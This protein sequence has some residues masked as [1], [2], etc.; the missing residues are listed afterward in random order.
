MIQNILD[1]EFASRRASYLYSRPSMILF[2][3]KAAFPS[4]SH[5]YMWDM[6]KL[7]GVHVYLIH[8]FQQF[9]RG[10]LQRIKVRKCLSKGFLAECGVRQGCPLSPLLF[11]AVVDVLLRRLVRRYEG[12][13]LRAFADDIG[14]VSLYLS[15]WHGILGDFV[16]FGNISGLHLNMPKCVLVPLWR[17]HISQLF[18]SL[19]DDFPALSRMQIAYAAKY[20]GVWLG[21]ESRGM[22]WDGAMRKFVDCARRWSVGAWGLHFMAR[23]YNIYVVS[24]LSYIAQFYP[25]SAAVLAAERKAVARCLP[26]PAN[27][28]R[29]EEA[30]RL[31]DWFSLGVQFTS[32]EHLSLASRLRVVHHEQVELDNILASLSE[33][34]ATGGHRYPEWSE[35]YHDHVF[36]ALFEA[37]DW[38]QARGSGIPDISRLA[39]EAAPASRRGDAGDVSRRLFQRTAYSLAISKHDFSA[40]VQT[41][42]RFRRWLPRI[43]AA[44]PDRPPQV[45]YVS[46]CWI[47]VMQRLS[48]MVSPCVRAAVFATVWNRW[49]TSRRF[50]SQGVCRFGCPCAAGS[51]PDDSLEHYFYC[52]TLRSW[53]SRALLQRSAPR[54]VDVQAFLCADDSLPDRDLVLR[55]VH[56]YA[57]YV[58]HNHLRHRGASAPDDS[59]DFYRRTVNQAL[60]MHS[61]STAL[62]RRGHD[63]AAPPPNRRRL[64]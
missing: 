35:W 32:V 48:T 9:Y 14:I 15:Q 59:F 16:D 4:I 45:G 63:T 11:A 44:R 8:A 41:A 5:D 43:Q 25:P 6:L 22:T 21:P 29:L 31:K 52:G 60:T 18:K 26:G 30:H 13:T 1:L 42:R 58:T 57:A 7:M 64:S 19:C 28:I 33:A 56:L 37:V 47:R 36:Q 51:S 39:L 53:E 24:V 49:C 3:F 2:D 50:Q 40:E 61:T 38:Y 12:I 54:Q 17:T 10:N 20:L 23:I 55:A 27:W 46:R 34:C 62:W